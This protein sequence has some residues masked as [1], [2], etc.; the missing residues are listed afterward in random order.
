MESESERVLLSKNL[1]EM[2]WNLRVKCL[3]T[4]LCMM[5][6]YATLRPAW[7]A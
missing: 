7:S 2:S 4:E 5:Y 6:T 1:I 3:A